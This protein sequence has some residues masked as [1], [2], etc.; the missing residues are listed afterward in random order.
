MITDCLAFPCYDCGG[1]VALVLGPGNT[2]QAIL[3]SYC[4]KCGVRYDASVMRMEMAHWMKAI[5][6]RVDETSKSS[7]MRVKRE[8]VLT[9][10]DRVWL[11]ELK[12][13]WDEEKA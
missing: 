10:E 4:S 3:A 9:E 5:V 13:K 6:G 11:S 1:S 12:V 2:L 7:G 8:P